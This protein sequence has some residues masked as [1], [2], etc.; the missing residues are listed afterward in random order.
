[1]YYRRLRVM[2]EINKQEKSKNGSLQI[3]RKLKPLHI[4]IIVVAFVAIVGGIIAF[5][6]LSQKNTPAPNTIVTPDNIKQV[7][8]EMDKAEKTP[9]GSFNINMNKTWHFKDSSTASSDSF[10]N[11]KPTNSNSVFITVLLKENQK[12]VYKSPD[13]PVGSALKNVKLDEALPKGTYPAVVK[14]NLIDD[15]KAV[16]STVSVNITLEILK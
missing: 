6:V 8:K 10:V 16:I 12:E 5:A 11:N 13:I 9:M 1:M 7:L 4:A 3:K 14:Y 15:K 2:S